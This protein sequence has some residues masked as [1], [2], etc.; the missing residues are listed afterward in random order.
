MTSCE[1][2][3]II[4]IE[5]GISDLLLI[6]LTSIVPEVS[7]AASTIY[8][9]QCGSNVLVVFHQLAQHF[10]W[11]HIALVVVL[12]GLQF[13]DCPIERTVV[14]PILRTRSARRR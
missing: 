3:T 13:R 14:P 7:R 12:D 2:N 1:P 5:I 6:W 9:L 8:A 10:A 11:R 4:E